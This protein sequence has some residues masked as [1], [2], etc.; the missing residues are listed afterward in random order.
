MDAQILAFTLWTLLYGL[1]WYVFELVVKVGYALMQRYGSMAEDV[2]SLARVLRI[3]IQQQHIDT[4][5]LAQNPQ[6]YEH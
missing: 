1:V 6:P 5:E 2:T 4:Q 3:V